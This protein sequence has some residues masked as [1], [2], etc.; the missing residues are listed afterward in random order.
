M[1]DEKCVYV[2]EFAHLQSAFKSF[3]ILFI[4]PYYLWN[5][6]EVREISRSWKWVEAFK[7]N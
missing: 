7:V 3:L 4:L 2:L 1:Y 5:D 6:Y